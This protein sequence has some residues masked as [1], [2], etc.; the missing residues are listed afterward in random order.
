MSGLSLGWAKRMI[1]EG[2]WWKYL[3]LNESDYKAFIRF[4]VQGKLIEAVLQKSAKPIRDRTGYEIAAKIPEYLKRFRVDE[5]ML[6]VI[7]IGKQLRHVA[8]AM[9]AKGFIMLN[10][11]ITEIN[12]CRKEAGEWDIIVTVCG[13]YSR[14]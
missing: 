3:I 10:D 4:S 13:Q 5:S 2:F 6:H 11:K 7:R 8:D 14:A 12:F 9:R 1:K